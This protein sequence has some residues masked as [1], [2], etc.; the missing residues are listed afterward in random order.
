MRALNIQEVTDVSGGKAQVVVDVNV[1]Q[2]YV[3]VN[4][5]DGTKV[6]VL[7]K[8]DWSKWFKQPASAAA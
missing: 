2:K 6:T 1:P 7:V 8:V 5:V 3:S 4:V